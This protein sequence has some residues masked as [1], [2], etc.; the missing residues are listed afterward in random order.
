MSKKY[1]IFFITVLIFFASVNMAT[2][3]INIKPKYYEPHEE[4]VESLYEL[5]LQGS[6]ALEKKRIT[7]QG[8]HDPEPFGRWTSESASIIGNLNPIIK[9]RTVILCGFAFVPNIGVTGVLKIAD[10]TYDI[11]FSSEESCHEF[12]YDGGR[13]TKDVVI[14]GFTTKT[15]VEIGINNDTRELGVAIFQLSSAFIV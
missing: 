2:N 12:I 4:R 13:V 9:G 14:D 6:H 5:G 8:F 15:P 3:S 11:K 1:L 7:L 10:S